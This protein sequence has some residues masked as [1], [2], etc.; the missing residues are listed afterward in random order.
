MRSAPSRPTPERT[1][2]FV[3]RLRNE[4]WSAGGRGA[5]ARNAFARIDDANP[6][7]D[8]GCRPACRSSGSQALLNNLNK[9]DYIVILMMENRSFDPMLGYLSLTGG[10]DDVNGLQVRDVAPSRVMMAL[11][12]R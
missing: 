1:R 10:L 7:T 11:Q 5:R 6:E 8:C 9:I 3:A 12:Q 2:L 4:L